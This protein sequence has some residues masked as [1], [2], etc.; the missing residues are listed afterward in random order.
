MIIF[1]FLWLLTVMVLTVIGVERRRRQR[2]RFAQA[3]QDFTK[4][5]A[6]FVA[7]VGRK[8]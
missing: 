5:W 3:I 4:S 7:A 6:R 2:A 8:E 1:G